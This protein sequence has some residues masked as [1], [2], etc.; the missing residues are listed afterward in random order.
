MHYRQFGKLGFRVSAL[1]FGA[2]RLPILDGK[3]DEVQA[4]RMLR[5]SI[6]NGVNY[7]DTAYTYH[8][9]AGEGLVGRALRA[10]YREKVKVATK[11][12]CWEVKKADDFDRLL[13]EQ[14]ARLS[15]D[16]IDFC[17]G[18]GCATLAC[19]NGKFRHVGFSF[20]DTFDVF[21]TIID[22]YDWPMC[23]IQYNFMDPDGQAGVRGLRYAASK[24]IAV[25]I[26]EPFW[27]G[28]S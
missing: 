2:M 1:G 16:S 10:G 18:P 11:L 12:P 28:S 21:K 27:A 19:A 6:D 3:I 25:A 8:G 22:E 17:R 20:H 13:D 9:G 26:M 14:L 4:T 5:H 24:G 23:Q 15:L 7:V